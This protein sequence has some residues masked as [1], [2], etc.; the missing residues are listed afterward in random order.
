MPIPRKAR[1]RE[2]VIYTQVQ[3]A[4]VEVS[5]LTSDQLAQVSNPEPYSFEK[6]IKKWHITVPMETRNEFSKKKE[7]AMVQ[8]SA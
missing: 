2:M 3:R 1:W 7:K 5:P 6:H 8:L 4:L